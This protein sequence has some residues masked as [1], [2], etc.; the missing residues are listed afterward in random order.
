MTTLFYV[1]QLRGSLSE[2]KKRKIFFLPPH[3]VAALP[4]PHPFSQRKEHKVRIKIKKKKYKEKKREKFFSLFL[5]LSPLSPFLSFFVSFF[6]FY[7]FLKT[8]Y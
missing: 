1:K 5:F 6:F 8:L 7:F 2:V 3:T 4:P